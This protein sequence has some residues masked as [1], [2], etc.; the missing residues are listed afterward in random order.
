MNATP[1]APRVTIGVPVFNEEA[2]LGEALESLMAQDHP[3][4]LIVISDNGS[5][6]RTPDIARAAAAA[7]PRVVFTRFPEN[8]G[9]LANYTKVLDLAQGD[10]IAWASGH[11]LW[12]ENFVSECAALLESHPKA[13][14]AFATSRWI[15]TEGRALPKEYGWTDTRGMDV[16]A[17]FFAVLWGNVHPIFGL[18]RLSYV[19]ELP[20]LPSSVGADLIFLC[21]MA[22]RGDLLHAPGALVMR[23]QVRR[24]ESHNERMNRY[25]RKDM[26]LAASPLARIFPALGLPVELV[27][28]V[29]GSRLAASDKA[30]ILAALAAAFPSRYLAGRKETAARLK[31]S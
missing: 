24:A 1:K 2:F 9:I 12:S 20:R 27:R 28:T 14:L 17:R 6:D 25:R 13:A 3:N 22:L 5:T 19:R 16:I 30:A 4:L 29:L 26:G 8:R 10:Y 7:D 15:D 11:D 21:E 23:R 18:V 31:M